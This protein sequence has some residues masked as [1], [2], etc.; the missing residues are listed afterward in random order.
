MASGNAHYL[1]YAYLKDTATVVVRLEFQCATLACPGAGSYQIRVQTLTDSSTWSGTSWYSISD[2]P[3]YL[4]IDWQASPASSP[5]TGIL[6]LWTD[7][8]LKQAINNI[9]NDTRQIDWVRLGAVAGIDTG[10]RGTYY[11]DAFASTRSSYIGQHYD[12]VAATFVYDGDGRRVKGTVNGVTTVIVGDHYEVRTDGESEITREYYFAGGRPIAERELP[13][14][15][16]SWLITDHL[17]SISAVADA[18][19]NLVAEMR[20]RAFGDRRV[21]GGHPTH[22]L[23]VHGP[24]G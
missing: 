6:K 14:G 12:N 9:D 16:L 7:G 21:R 4:E 3:H 15:K 10:T 20:Y 22:L 18:G 2:A 8:V 1:F 23:P 5:S 24:A 11:F 19:G 17:G 13:S